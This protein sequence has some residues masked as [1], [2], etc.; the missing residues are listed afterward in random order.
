M[1]IS[2]KFGQ[3]RR[4]LEIPVVYLL[5]IKYYQNILIEKKTI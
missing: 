2:K 1:P 3:N 4:K 5:R